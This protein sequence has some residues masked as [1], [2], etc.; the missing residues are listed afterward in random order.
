M[1][2][3]AVQILV[4]DDEASI[5]AGCR[6]VLTEQGYDVVVRHT[7]ASGLEVLDSLCPAIVL[8]DMR[9]PDMKGIDVLGQIRQRQP[10]ANVVVMTGYASVENAVAAMKLGAFDYLS[11]PFSDDE[12]VLAVGRAAENVRLRSENLSLRRQLSERYG[13]GNIV[14]ENDKILLIFEKIR[15]VAPT[16]TTVLLEGESGTG[17]E[18]FARAIHAHSNRASRQFVALDCSTLSGG[19]LES[20]LFGH[21]KGA[22]TGADQSTP[23]IFQVADGGTLFLDEVGNLSMET[24]S[25]LLRVMETREYKPVGASA[26]KHTDIRIIAATNRSL[27]ALVEAG[28][29]RSDLLY[30]LNTV[31]IVIPPLRQRRDD[32]PRLAYH[33]L[34]LFC[35]RSGKQIKGFSDE[36]L[37]I[38]VN[39]QW[40]GNVRQL[41]N[42]VE[43]LVIMAEQEYLDGSTVEDHVQLRRKGNG[44]T[45]P[46][47]LEELK[48]YKKHLIEEQ[49]GQTERAFLVRALRASEGNISTAARA[50]GMQRSNFSTLMKKHGISARAAAAGGDR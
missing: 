38:L 45:V 43:R 13:F 21:V 12:L 36:A 3:S 16:D 31:P 5:G 48:A 23:G 44:I 42:A 10:E 35:R 28:T 4:I 39:H 32:I 6:L 30:R 24:Q 19:L 22:F 7:G 27:K 26:V 49:Y 50:V 18:L 15:K 25:K 37:E 14:G 20:E 34:R 17:K 29:F 2:T 33:F 9:L 47:T 11:K 40:P 46:E 8:L 1:E 41:K